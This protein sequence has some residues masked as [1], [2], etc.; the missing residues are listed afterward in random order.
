MWTPRDRF[1]K[2]FFDTEELTV[3]EP[4]KVEGIGS[5]KIPGALDMS[6]VDRWIT[7]TDAESFAMTRRVAR[8]E[9]LFAGGSS[10]L[11]VYAAVEV[12]KDAGEDAVVVTLLSDWGEHYLTKVYDDDWMRENGFLKRAHHSVHHL[13]AAKDREL[14]RAGH[15]SAHHTGASRPL[16]A[17]IVQR[18]A[19]TCNL[20]R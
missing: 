7:V 8:E 19:V 4:Y 5:D 12:A 16:D 9:G 17:H 2:A 6:V 10:G 14:P 1:L 11:V 3:G 20:G 15:G 13:V 18:V